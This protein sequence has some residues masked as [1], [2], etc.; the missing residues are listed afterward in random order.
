M[1]VGRY[2][3]CCRN[4]L[5]IFVLIFANFL[6]AYMLFH[7]GNVDLN[8]KRV[9]VLS[10]ARSGSS[11]I[12]EMTSTLSSSSNTL[13]IFEPFR[14]TRQDDSFDGGVNREGEIHHILDV[15]FNC[16]P[17]ERLWGIWQKT[18]EE[19]KSASIIVIKTVRLRGDVFGRWLRL[20]RFEV[21]VVHL[22]RDPR[23]RYYSMINAPG[24]NMFTG[25]VTNFGQVCKSMEEDFKL[26]EKISEN[27]Y[28]LVQYEKVWKDPDRE[29]KRIL[30]FLRLEFNENHRKWLQKHISDSNPKT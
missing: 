13:Y 14:A 25:A 12:G 21:S 16:L 22:V 11:F 26:G 29:M 19:C 30:H 2:K 4:N 5:L 27:L 23:A 28:L 20:Q 8:K 24:Y 15:I 1:F 18:V 3:K 9:L 6:F 7:T 17:D 10:A